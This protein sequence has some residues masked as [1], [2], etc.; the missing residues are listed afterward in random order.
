MNGALVVHCGSKELAE[1]FLNECRQRDIKVGNK[2]K[3]DG[4]WC[5]RFVY[6]KV[7]Y[8]VPAYYREC[9]YEIVK[10]GKQS[11][12]IANVLQNIKDGEIYKCRG[13]RIECKNGCILI[14]DDT[15]CVSFSFEDEFEKVEETVNREVALKAMIEGKV[16]KFVTNDHNYRLNKDLKVEVYSLL[17]WM[18]RC[19]MTDFLSKGKENEEW[20]ILQ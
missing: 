18:E 14:G 7:L 6:G 10:W 13:K 9:G 3:V 16:V 4:D 17:G 11:T 19:T 8:D 12:T 1:D 2:V 15:G 20:I 5:Y